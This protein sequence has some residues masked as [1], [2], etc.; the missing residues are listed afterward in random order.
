VA[1]SRAQGGYWYAQAI[2]TSDLPP[3][4]GLVALVIAGAADSESGRLKVSLTILARRTGLGRSTV[5]RTLKTLEAEGWVKR[6]RPE[7]WKAI[8]EG[9]STVYT[10]II[11][12]GYPTK[13]SPAAGL[14][15]TKASARAGLGVVP[16]T[17]K[18]SPAAGLS[19]TSTN[20]AAA[21]SA[22]A[23][24]RPLPLLCPHNVVHGLEVNDEGALACPTCEAHAPGDEFPDWV[25]D[26]RSRGISDDMVSDFLYE[27]DSNNDWQWVAEAV[28]GR[29]L[30]EA[31]RPVHPR[32]VRLPQPPA[33]R[34]ARAVRP[35]LHERGPHPR[36]AEGVR[37][38]LAI[39]VCE[40][41]RT[42]E[43]SCKKKHSRQGLRCCPSCDHEGTSDAA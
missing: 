30:P 32:R 27:L 29:G 3:T 14:G 22:A 31:R 19:T 9:D 8:K 24:P 5:A 39:T 43:A 20:G 37:M 2:W 18:A 33:P 36:L 7:V 26:M 16:E 21:G 28:A 4:A 34:M 38:T 12:A 35:C 13:A 17:T 11:P 40:R 10:T 42:S 41:C 6:S 1:T 23:P 15:G 25:R